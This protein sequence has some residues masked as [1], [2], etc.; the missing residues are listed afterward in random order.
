MPHFIEPYAEAAIHIL[1]L[2]SGARF[3][4]QEIVEVPSLLAGLVITYDGVTDDTRESYQLSYDKFLERMT[5]VKPDWKFFKKENFEKLK[6]VPEKT[7]LGW[8]GRTI[9]FL[10]G[11]SVPAQ[12]SADKGQS[13]ALALL[14]AS[15]A[16]L[17][18]LVMA[19][20]K[21]LK[22]AIPPGRNNF[23]DFEHMVRIVFN[24]LF[25]G[26]LGEGKAQSRTEPENEGVEIRDVIFAN[27]ASTGFW[28]D[29]KNKYSVSEVVVDAKNTEDV[30]REDI[31]Q[32]YCYL[33]P[34][35]GYWGF[36]VCRAPPSNTIQTFNRTLCKNFRQD[37]GLLILC[38][39]DLRRMIEMKNRGTDPA[40]Y[41]QEKMS[42]FVRSL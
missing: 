4:R 25:Q 37:R 23:R 27:Q 9:Y 10:R 1:H 11:G 20:V 36:I 32:L 33:K 13:D 5:R 31:R 28:S 26:Q 42:E 22:Q 15:H 3:F 41:L 18:P 14:A 40:L 6:A 2:V 29:L 30:T 39:D 17:G 24:Y 12:W 8:E 38:D 35:L 19:E 21:Q 16:M 7:L 34:A